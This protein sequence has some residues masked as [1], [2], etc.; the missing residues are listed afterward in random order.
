MLSRWPGRTP[1]LLPVATRQREDVN[2][3]G[4]VSAVDALLVIN[5]PDRVEPSGESTGATIR[6]AEEMDADVNHDGRITALDAL[7]VVNYLGQQRSEGER[8]NQS[9]DR[10]FSTNISSV[11]SSD[12]PNVVSVPN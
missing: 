3:D 2:A 1:Q 5:L 12:E 8:W 6:G 7:A 9:V 11:R 4:R 10:F